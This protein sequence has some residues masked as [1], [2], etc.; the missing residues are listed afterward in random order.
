MLENEAKN[1][2]AQTTA[3]PQINVVPKREET[4]QTK[5]MKENFSFF[6]PVT[7]AYAVFYAFCMFHNGSG[8]T[9]PFFLA[10]TLLY[11]VFSWSKLGITLKKGSSFYMIAIMLLGISTFCTDGWAIINLNKLAVFLL[12]M[13][14]LL[15][16]FF[17]TSKWNFG[18]YTGSICQLIIMSFGELESPFKDGRSFFQKR[19]KGNKKLWYG[20]LGALI[21]L[22]IL[23]IVAGLLSSADV[24]FREMTLNFVEWIKPLNIINIFARI[25][26]LFFAAY[27]MTAYLCKRC[28]REEVVDRRTGEPV[29]AITIMSLLSL[30]YL[31]F[32]GIQIF[33]LFMGKMQLP[34]RYT[35]AQYARE[36]FFQLLA[37]SILN[38][39]LVLVCLNFFRESKLLKAIMTVMSL[40]TFVMIASSAMRMIIYIRYY[41]LTFLRI[42]VLWMLAVLFVMFI[43][44]L[45]SI[46]RE[47]FPL[48]RYGIVVVTILYLALSFSHPDYII[49][50]VNIA[51]APGADGVGWVESKEQDYGND[52]FSGPFFRGSEYTD[53]SY[54]RDL[55]ADAAPVMIPYIE[56]MGFDLTA[57]ELEN[58]SDILNT[59]DWG[60][61]RQEFG[62]DYL[63]GIK[64]RMSK[65]SP[66]T[67]NISRYMALRQIEGRIYGK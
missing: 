64:Y 65:M 48:F 36:G 49:A 47:S 50:R 26:F 9:F 23:L 67:F 57:Y 33:G 25:I 20:L 32:S 46:Y 14:L 59:D 54:L 12:V 53:Y 29:L 27:A 52:F 21:A 1:I 44:V 4:P 43:G 7:F 35:Y 39:I 10:G 30:L 24:L 15:R 62:Y 37:V 40:C 8:I 38:L 63:A 19:G 18:K 42:F 34:E 60:Y 22:P 13:C 45:I 28:I 17:D 16:Q 41:Y 61:I 3:A 58:P 66:R 11:F 2:T 56:S 6:G 5:Y 51:N 31:L 55:S